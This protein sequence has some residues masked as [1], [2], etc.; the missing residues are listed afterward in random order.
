MD[1]LDEAKKKKKAKKKS[2]KKK[3]STG[4]GAWLPNY[5]FYQ[6]DD[7]YTPSLGYGS[8]GGDMGGGDFGG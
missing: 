2:K 6:T 3:K 4:V 1:E 5:G 8:D 7:D